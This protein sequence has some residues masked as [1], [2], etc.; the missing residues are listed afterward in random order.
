[1]LFIEFYR[2]KNLVK[3]LKPYDD[4]TEEFNHFKNMFILNMVYCLIEVPFFIIGT[5]FSFTHSSD[6]SATFYFLFHYVSFS[7][8]FLF[9]Y[10]LF[11]DLQAYCDN[12]RE[13]IFYDAN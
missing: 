6:R 3:R 7:L 2:L 5:D 10:V 11:K 12:L 13:E 4:L 1:M 8:L 9:G